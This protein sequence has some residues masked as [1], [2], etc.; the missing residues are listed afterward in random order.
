MTR[1]VS[2][3]RG[4]RKGTGQIDFRGRSYDHIPEAPAASSR[5]N[6]V[7]P[8]LVHFMEH[9]GTGWGKGARV[10]GIPAHKGALVLRWRRTGSA[11]VEAAQIDQGFLRAAMPI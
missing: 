6:A 1:G 5:P 4:G 11:V 9:L 7:S 8:R 2:I 10:K 3:R